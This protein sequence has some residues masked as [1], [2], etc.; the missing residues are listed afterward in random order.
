M[1]RIGE[2]LE[3]TK[4]C[5]ADYEIVMSCLYPDSPIGSHLKHA[6]RGYLRYT[7][8]SGFTFNIDWSNKEGTNLIDFKEFIKDKSI[9]EDEELISWDEDDGNIIDF[10]N[11]MIKSKKII[12]C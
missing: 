4:E 1:L 10:K 3:L 11:V 9:E 7:N 2:F 6:H 12:L 8:S 5:E